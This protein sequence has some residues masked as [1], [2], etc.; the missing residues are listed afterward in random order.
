M[1]KSLFFLSFITI[2]AAH[3]LGQ[4]T[5]GVY[6][7]SF[8]ISSD[9]TNAYKVQLGTTTTSSNHALIYFSDAMVDSMKRIIIQ[10]VEKQMSAKAEYTYRQTKSGK[11]IQTGNWGNTVRG[12]PTGTKRKAIRNFE[13]DFYVRVSIN[14]S[15]RGGLSYPML[16]GQHSSLRP[17]ITFKIVAFDA[18]RKKVFKRKVKAKDFSKLKSVQRTF[19]NVTVKQSEVLHQEDIYY[20]LK[21]VVE[22]FDK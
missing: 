20:M 14:V 5:A 16:D 4:N 17:M 18:M 11:F 15:G 19:N 10:T 21:K 7:V 8:Q 22:Q 9:L 2:V 1:M 13:K 6:D 3:V 12:L